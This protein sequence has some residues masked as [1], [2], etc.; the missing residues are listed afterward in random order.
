MRKAPALLF[1]ASSSL[2]A[3]LAVPAC[4]A[5]NDA[6]PDAGDDEIA[7]GTVTSVSSSDPQDWLWIHERTGQFAS[8]V[9][10]SALDALIS[11]GATFCVDDPVSTLPLFDGVWHDLEL[12]Y[13]LPSQGVTFTWTRDLEPTQS[14]IAPAACPPAA[15]LPVILGL[16]HASEPTR[17][18]AGGVDPIAHVDW[19]YVRALASPG[20]DPAVT[21]TPPIWAVL[22][23]GG[24][25][26]SGG[27][28]STDGD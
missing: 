3:A 9:S 12:T 20:P 21:V 16:D 10:W 25:A 8:L 17:G 22:D 2:L 28:A 11:G 18:S 1:F 23:A 14:F 27:D 24:D 4:G 15:K 5:L 13:G 19:V 26:S 6:P 7:A